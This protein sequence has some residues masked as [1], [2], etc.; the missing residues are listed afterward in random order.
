MPSGITA[1]GNF[2]SPR[3]IAAPGPTR[4]REW[5]SPGGV[6]DLADSPHPSSP[7]ALTF[8]T[9][10]PG[11]L[12]DVNAALKVILFSRFEIS[13]FFIFFVLGQASPFPLY[14][15]LQVPEAKWCHRSLQNHPPLVGSKPATFRPLITP[16]AAFLQARSFIR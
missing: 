10:F 1:R 9:F 2:P 7:T 4:R 13:F 16:H 14:A 6:P 8:L 5:V 12:N 11:I 15:L 3:Q